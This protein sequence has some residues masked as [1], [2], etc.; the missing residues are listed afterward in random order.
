[1]VN[2][3]VELELKKP[4]DGEDTELKEVEIEAKDLTKIILE[5]IDK[6]IEGRECFNWLEAML[7]VH[8]SEAYGVLWDI[9]QS[10][11]DDINHNPRNLPPETI[12]YIE[13]LNKMIYE[14]NVMDYYF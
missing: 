12:K 8:S 1:M 2:I 14:S 6:D 9:Q 5:F 3:K 10:L 13:E 4:S 11:W 7:Y